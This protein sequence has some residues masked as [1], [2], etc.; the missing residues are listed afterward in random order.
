MKH[1]IIYKITNLI[2]NM[3]YIGCHI[4][5]NI[6]DGYLGSGVLIKEAINKQGKEDFLKE[7]LFDFSSFKEMIEKEKEIVDE[8]FVARI[9]TY[10]LTK[11]GYSS[12][13]YINQNNLN[14]SVNQYLI[15][16][17]RIKKDKEYRKW[18]SKKVSN[19]LKLYFKHNKSHWLGKKH[20]EDS[21]KKIGEANSIYQK[22]KGNSQYGTMWITNGVDNKKI[23]KD[24]VIPA[25]WYKGRK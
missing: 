6:N 7:I 5:E 23:K 21:K 18:F 10:N 25:E 11:G 15:S 1:Y 17:K 16:S 3:I 9:D 19:G 24:D 14:N 8:V 13:Y 12:Y 20:T 22:G 4:T 2:N